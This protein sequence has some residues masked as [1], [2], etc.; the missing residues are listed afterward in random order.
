[1]ANNYSKIAPGIVEDKQEPS[2]TILQFILNYSKS[3][4]VKKNKQESL[5]IN[6]N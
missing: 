1:M 2:K 6:L 4:E 3:V 5:L